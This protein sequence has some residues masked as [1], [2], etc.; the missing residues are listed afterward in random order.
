MVNS[1][2][3]EGQRWNHVISPLN[4]LFL[5]THRIVKN[6]LQIWEATHKISQPLIWNLKFEE[7]I[8]QKHTVHWNNLHSNSNSAHSNKEIS[9]LGRRID[10]YIIQIY[11]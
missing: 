11:Q 9:F 4:F 1:R 10:I 8:K 5:Y 6:G 7:T 3:I 2:K